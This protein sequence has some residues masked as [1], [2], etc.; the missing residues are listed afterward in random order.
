M[1]IDNTE[2]PSRAKHQNKY[3]Q[4]AFASIFFFQF[5]FVVIQ[6]LLH[7]LIERQIPKHLAYQLL[8]RILVHFVSLVFPFDSNFFVRLTFC[9]IPADYIYTHLYNSI[10]ATNIQFFEFE[11]VC[12]FFFLWNIKLQRLGFG[13]F[14]YRKAIY[15]QKSDKRHT[16]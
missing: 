11:I 14:G 8:S 12:F 13:G 15:H 6:T 4:F 7:S 16:K 5:N 10:S 9:G 1:N 2:K 3:F